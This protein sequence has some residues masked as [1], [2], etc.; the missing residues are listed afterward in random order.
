MAQRINDLSIKFPVNTNHGTRD[1]LTR[2]WVL[3]IN[4][5]FLGLCQM[6]KGRRR[7]FGVGG[8]WTERVI[9]RRRMPEGMTEPEK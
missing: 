8:F 6:H 1:S 2:Y 4:P 5:R 9:G 7:E 3:T